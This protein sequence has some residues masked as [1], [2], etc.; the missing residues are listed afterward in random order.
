MTDIVIKLN[1]EQHMLVFQRGLERQWAHRD[2]NGVRVGT[3]HKFETF[4]NDFLADVAGAAAE[5]AVAEYYGTRWNSETWNLSEHKHHTVAPDVEPH[6]EVR[7]V[8]QRSGELTIRWSDLDYKIA[9]LTFVEYPENRSVHI[10]GGMSV[11]EA[12]ERYQ[13]DEKGNVYVP[14]EDLYHPDTFVVG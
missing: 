8:I 9:I 6:F 11:K 10:Y 1:R 4:Q 7:R 13:A 2:D 12:R 3:V 5:C 14:K